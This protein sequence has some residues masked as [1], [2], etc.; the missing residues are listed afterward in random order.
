MS[1][2]INGKTVK[3][4]MEALAAPLPKEA[5]KVRDYDNKPYITVEACYERMDSVLGVEHYNAVYTEPQFV[6]QKDTYV[7]S[8]VGT[9]EI[10]D[11]NF[12]VIFRKS[13]PGTST[14][15]FPNIEKTEN[16]QKVKVPG[17]I[18][19]LVPNDVMSAFQDAFKRICK[20][21]LQIGAKQLSEFKGKTTGIQFDSSSWMIRNYVPVYRNIPLNQLLCWSLLV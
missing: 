4:V 10:L 17:N 6:Q 9:L 16:G 19:T 21:K 14:V 1:R 3:E 18:A 15:T 12:E 20:N 13:G 8:T 2:T 7:I 5:F 11:D